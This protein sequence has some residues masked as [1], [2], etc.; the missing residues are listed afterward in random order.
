MAFPRNMGF[1]VRWQRRPR[2]LRQKG[3]ILSV[4]Y[5]GQWYRREIPPDGDVTVREAARLLG[6]SVTAVEKHI[7]RGTIAASSR[8]GARVIP[9]A[10]I[11]A[12][13]LERPVAAERAG[14]PREELVRL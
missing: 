12:Y 1:R 2:D 3:V 8:G 9:L 10:S 7:H 11:V 5:N 4:C 13:L 14:V 6:I